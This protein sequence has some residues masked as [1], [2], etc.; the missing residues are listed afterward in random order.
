MAEMASFER[1]PLLD[2]QCSFYAKDSFR[3]DDVWVSH[4][5]RVFFVEFRNF[6]GI[7]FSCEAP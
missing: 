1:W 2:V 6:L 4:G 7:I 3:V 5:N